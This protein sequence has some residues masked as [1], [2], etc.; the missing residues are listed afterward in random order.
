MDIIRFLG[1]LLITIVIAF[2]WSLLGVLIGINDVTKL[3]YW[4][5][6]FGFLVVSYIGFKIGRIIMGKLIP[7][8]DEPIPERDTEGMKEVIKEWGQKGFQNE[9]NEDN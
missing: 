3:A 9:N 4:I 8:Q 7:K 2:W 1:T 6:G 5:F